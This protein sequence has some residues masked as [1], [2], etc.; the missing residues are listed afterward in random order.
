MALDSRTPC[1]TEACCHAPGGFFAKD[2]AVFQAAA[3][4]L[5]D[6]STRRPTKFRRLLV[7]RDLFAVADKDASAA[8][9]EARGY[10]GCQW[11]G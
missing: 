1:L 7:A 9:F 11:L 8:L 2:M 10:Y 5:L 3:G 4:V 6:P